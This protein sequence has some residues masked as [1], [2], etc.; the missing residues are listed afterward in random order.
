M[1]ILLTGASGFIGTALRALLEQKGHKVE[2]IQRVTQITGDNQWVMATGELQLAHHDFDVFIHLASESVSNQ[3]W[4]KNK[5]QRIITSRLEHTQKLIQSLAALKHLPTASPKQFIC[6]SGISIYADAQRA[7]EADNQISLEQQAGSQFTW[8]KPFLMQTLSAQRETF[9]MQLNAH[10]W[11][12]SCLRLGVVYD[13]NAGGFAKMLALTQAGKG[14]TFAGGKQF[15]SWISRHDALAAIEFIMQHKLTGSLNVTA[16]NP[17]RNAELVAKL[18]H[19]L[20]VKARFNKP[21][22]LLRL[23]VGN[24]ADEFLLR[25]LYV[26]PKRLQAAGFTFKHANI[27]QL[28][29]TIER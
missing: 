8:Q 27:D 7:D 28:I 22:W 20:Q 21:K 18:A 12:V 19:K 9:A 4:S 16:P 6:A 25:S 15:V 5:I 10:N 11:Q 2:S 3:R 17:I 26:M 1:H 13:I 14:G 29:A 24:M 23:L